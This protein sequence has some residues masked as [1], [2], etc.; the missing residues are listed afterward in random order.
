MKRLPCHS[1]CSAT[2]CMACCPAPRMGSVR[3]RSEIGGGSAYEER[4]WAARG[5][6]GL[7]QGAEA[8]TA[9]AAQLHNS[10]SVRPL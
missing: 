8:R 1:Y 4:R 3:M 2:S 7:W 9:K 6:Y 5:N 10:H